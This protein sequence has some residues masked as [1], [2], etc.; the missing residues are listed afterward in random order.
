MDKVC[1]FRHRAGN[2]R[3]LAET[4]STVT[5]RNHYAHIA[6][7]WDKLADERL[8]F[9]VTGA[10]APA[11]GSAPADRQPQAAPLSQT[12]WAE[13]SACEHFVQ[14]YDADDVFLN[15]LADF[16]ASGL[17]EG[18][19]TV[20][21]ATPEHRDA[22]DERLG[23][24][25][26]NVRSAKADDRFLSLDAQEILGSFMREGW[27]DEE[28]F[29]TT[30]RSI[31]ERAGRGGR[32]VRAFGEMV[33]LLWAEGFCEATVRLEHLWQQLC[34]AESFALFCAYPRSGFTEDPSD[35]IARVCAAHSKVFVG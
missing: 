25:G 15:S 23:R 11:I 17:Y 20:V 2:C 14:I 12:F 10:P 5:I 27:P 26:I 3:E 4:S 7:I 29:A 13:M 22:L 8:A 6:R 30:V 28:Q 16:L 34:D 32:K 24:M 18:Q 35:S 9:F 21:I 33:A 31:L 1:E 19:G